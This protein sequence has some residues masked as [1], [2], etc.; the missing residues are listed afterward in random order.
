V[1][2]QRGND[3][4]QRTAGSWQRSTG[5][6]AGGARTNNP[7]SPRTADGSW[8]DHAAAAQQRAGGGTFQERDPSTAAHA[9]ART[10]D[11]DGFRPDPN[12]NFDGS[13]RG[14]FARGETNYADRGNAG[15][16]GANGAA[17]PG[18][19]TRGGNWNGGGWG[20]GDQGGTYAQRWGNDYDRGIP[21]FNQD[22]GWY[23]RTVS[24]PANPYGYGY[25]Y[26]YTGWSNG[27]RGMGQL[28]GWGGARPGGGGVGGG[29]R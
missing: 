9:Q 18:P 11:Y 15:A 2:Q 12:H 16:S 28:S 14:A 8:R 19:Y 20:V 4:Y 17:Q 1:M 22:T 24:R 23:D 25:G 7:M 21:G 26:G 27:Y 6:A 13:P 3:T 29:R 10:A 5:D